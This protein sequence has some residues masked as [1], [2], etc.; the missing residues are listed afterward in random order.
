MEWF[1]L[2]LESVMQDC[3]DPH[4]NVEAV[5]Q[6]SPPAAKIAL[7]RS[8]FRGRNDVY[9][10]RFESRK[11]GKAGYSPA[12]A[13][14]WV[15]GICEKPRIKCADCSFRC[16]LPVTD[17]AIRRHLSGGTEQGHEF[18]M[19]VYPMLLDE[20]C[21]FLAIDF[22]RENWQDDTSAFLETCRRFDLPAA[23]ER[24]RSGNGGHVWIFFDHP[25]A[26]SLARKLG[27][28]L[29]TETME[30]RPELGFGSYD[31][32]FPNQDTLPK[33]GFGNLIA[34]PLQKRARQLGNTVFLDGQFK[35]YPDQWAFLASVPKIGRHRVELLVR[36]AE[37]GGRTVGVRAVTTDEDD[38][39]PWNMPS[40]H[41]HHEPAILEP[42][43]ES[44]N[45]VLADQIYIA[46][47]NLPAALRNRLLRLAAFQNPEFYRAQSMRLP[48]YDKPRVIHCAEEYPQHL[49]LPRGC[50]DDAKS[51][52]QKLKIKII[53][54]DERCLGVP[55]DALFRGALRVEQQAAAEAMLECDTGVL[56]A[57]TAFGKT[58]VA[59][60]L[61]SQ[62]RVNT[63][64]L[65]HRQ[66]LL[67][68]WIERLSA[69]LEIPAK[70][71][72]RLGGGKKR[73]TGIL[74]VALIQSLVRKGK[75]DDRIQDYGYLIIDECHHL[76]ARSFE[77]VVRRAKA[78]FVT[79]LSATVMRKDGHHPIIFM[80]C[81]P[82]RYRVDAKN[83][84][85]AR[86]F[87]HQVIVRPTGFYS[88]TAP[89]Q[90]PR[91][92]FKELC[93]ALRIDDVRNQMICADA[94]NA[95]Q[96]GRSSLL[97]TERVQ[98]L[99]RLAQRLSP[100]APDLIVLHGGMGEKALRDTRARL[101]GLP[102]NVGCLI[103]ATGR[104]IGE[105]FDHPR[106][107][108]L[109]ITLPVSW[110]G[111]LAQYVG[112]LHRLHEGKREVRVYDYADLNVPMLSRMFER[113]CRGYEGLG[114]NLMLPASALPGWP[115]E[116]PLPVDPLWKKDYAGSIR[117]LIRDGVDTPLAN[118]F[119]HVAR[120][121]APDADGVARARSASEAFFYRR[122]ETL[123]EAARRF[124]LN[125]EL[126]IPF[127][128]WGRMEVDLLCAD[129]RLVVELD[130]AQHLADPEAYRRDRR[131][132]V[133]LQ[134]NGYMV[135]RFLAEDLG[136]RLDYVLDTVLG[137]LVNCQGRA[138]GGNCV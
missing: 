60:W 75:V 136:K 42:L 99:E 107:D 65:V 116:V 94:L 76:S 127:D 18:V 69:F 21:Y 12:C 78:R 24:S 13:N 11:T 51:L 37:I 46:R 85:A 52:F 98:H 77:M 22:D 102:G 62:R 86:P 30:R 121:F 26:A 28:Y 114:Y 74:D 68:Q 118:L 31:R 39:I 84:A 71:I 32:L 23:L 103:V 16:F 64:V 19:G 105:G 109:F 53:L 72:G 106:L 25:I 3:G 27:S 4:L 43:P 110:R 117:R 57:T 45:L 97:L 134:Q 58:V 83:Q 44:I 36:G 67:E 130:G 56:A 80:Q 129:A 119:V 2:R 87:V 124:Q 123:S 128:G 34:L 41:H 91:I 50:L 7:F 126:P 133:L 15:R 125:A 17:E 90:D 95:L 89:E 96:E 38:D 35:L 81:G 138:R 47:K 82:L 40:S 101:A 92:E 115:V 59:A 6:D 108:T 113:R 111:T 48:T 14:E 54:R 55:F 135:L 8:L 66:Q 33:G 122:L 112:R 20:T 104:Y 120:P 10:V 29:L 73:L 93:D 79:G 132:D 49:A 88:I 1:S 63:L 61:V 137:A 131:K 5:N 100:Q 70:A 9:P